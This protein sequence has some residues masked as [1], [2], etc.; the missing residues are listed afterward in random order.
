MDVD[1]LLARYDGSIAAIARAVRQTLVAQL[2]GITEEPD[3]TANVIGYGYGSG[4][5]GLICT[6]ILSKKGVKLGFYK[7]AALPD[8]HHLLQ[9]SGKVHRYVEIGSP[10]AAEDARLAELIQAAADAYRSR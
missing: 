7:G 6:L 1:A 2:P 5:K 3:A 10:E 9:G 8:P 4:Y